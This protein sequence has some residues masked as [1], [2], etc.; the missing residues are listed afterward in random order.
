MNPYDFVKANQDSFLEELKDLIRIPSISTLSEHEPDIQRAAEWLR[1]HL[2]AV[3][4]DR[5]EIYPTTGKPLV[6]AE[7]R[8]AGEDALTVVAYGH[9]DVQ[10]VDDPFN[11]WLSDP[12]EPEIR[13]GNL[14]ARGATDDKG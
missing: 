2:I 14:Y 3:G 9:Y 10:P 6:Y 8:G 1:D 4:M 13:N 7:Y 12:F 11:E 5:A